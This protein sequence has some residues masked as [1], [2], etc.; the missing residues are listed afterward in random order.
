MEHKPISR[1]AVQIPELA[2]KLFNSIGLSDLIYL[3]DIHV[4]NMYSPLSTV[5]L[6]DLLGVRNDMVTYRSRSFY[7]DLLNLYDLGVCDETVDFLSDLLGNS[8]APKYRIRI[9]DTVAKY[10][11]IEPSYK[12]TFKASTLSFLCFVKRQ[13]VSLSYYSAMKNRHLED[14]FKESQGEELY[15]LYKRMFEYYEQSRYVES[16]NALST[17]MLK[18]NKDEDIYLDY[19]MHRDLPTSVRQHKLL[20][21]S[22]NL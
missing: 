12:P 1:I 6:K 19:S 4:L 8:I 18:Q 16:L 10:W 2:L 22:W 9:D 7:E 14:S 21:Q 11:G 3:R 20:L 5:T 17:L 13:P 15:D